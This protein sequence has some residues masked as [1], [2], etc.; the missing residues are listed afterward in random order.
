MKNIV[1]VEIRDSSTYEVIAI[2][3][4]DETQFSDPHGGAFTL[5]EQQAF[6]CIAVGVMDGLV[7]HRGTAFEKFVQARLQAVFI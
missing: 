2:M 4:G 5:E 3:R 7:L 1:A 6:R